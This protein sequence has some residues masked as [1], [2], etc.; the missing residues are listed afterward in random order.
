MGKIN[1][2]GDYKQMIE[3]FGKNSYCSGNVYMCNIM[4]V[5]QKNK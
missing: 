4:K 1:N 5:S 3:M 2:S